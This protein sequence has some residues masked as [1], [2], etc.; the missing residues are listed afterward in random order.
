MSVYLRVLLG[1]VVILYF[2][3]IIHFVKKKALAL[4]YTLLW[5]FSGLAMGLLVLFPWGLKLFVRAVGIETPVYGLF[6]AGIIFLLLI[7]MSL[8]AIVSRQTERIRNLA[9]ANALLE[10]RVR[11]LEQRCR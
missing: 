7:A 3:L 6:L 4:K 10:K 5:M 9:Q 8:T 1:I 2:Y 11:E